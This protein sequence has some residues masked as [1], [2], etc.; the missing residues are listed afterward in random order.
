MVKINFKK[1]STLAKSPYKKDEFD[2]GWDFY[3]IEDVVLFP[4]RTSSVKTG[5]AVQMEWDLENKIFMPEI[6]KD[7]ELMNKMF[8]AMM[9][10]Y[11]VE[12][13]N[14]Y[15]QGESR[16]GLASKGIHWI[17]GVIDKGY[18]GEV[19]IVLS[20]NSK[21]AYSI[22]KGERIGQGVVNI[23]P[24]TKIEEVKELE[25]TQRG[26]KGFGSSGK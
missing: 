12:N 8:T 1:L 5:I 10:Q 4:G 18:S 11:F 22:K 21:Q 13:F 9:N 26:E 3:S 7:D 6:N 20:N 16:S 15:L 23:I 24:F 19:I 17:G 14:L 2:A 25:E